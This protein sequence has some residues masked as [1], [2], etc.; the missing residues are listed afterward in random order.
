M[1]AT[2]LNELRAEVERLTSEVE[3]R[4]ARV[5]AQRTQSTRNVARSLLR[6]AE[7]DLAEARTALRAHPDHQP[8][9]AVAAAH[10]EETLRRLDPE[11]HDHLTSRGFLAGLPALDSLSED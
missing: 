11:R 9:A 5:A 10:D 8:A 7:T 2:T 1:A 6:S 4:R 3:S